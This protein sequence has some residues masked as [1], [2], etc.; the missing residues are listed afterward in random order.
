MNAG[1]L[2][3]NA[4]NGSCRMPPP[5][6]RQAPTRAGRQASARTVCPPPACRSTATPMRMTDGREVVW[7][8]WSE[9]YDPATWLDRSV[10]ATRTEVFPLHG[11]DPAAW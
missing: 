10:H 9:G 7:R 8:D 2:T 11:L 3:G 5:G 1:Q 6:L 4:H